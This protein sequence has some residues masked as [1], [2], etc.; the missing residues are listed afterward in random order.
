MTFED[1][2]VVI[3]TLTS[4]SPRPTATNICALEINIVDKLKMIPS[5]QS[6]DFGYSGKVEADVVYAL[7][8]NIL[9]VD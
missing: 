2:L 3:G 5:K 4:L 9:W 7:K 6:V 1:A 8:T